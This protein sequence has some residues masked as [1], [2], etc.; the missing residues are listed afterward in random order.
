MEYKYFFVLKMK[1][2]LVRGRIEGIKRLFRQ[3]SSLLIN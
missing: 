3:I 1:L 2:Q